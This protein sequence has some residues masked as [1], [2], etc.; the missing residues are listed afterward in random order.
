M[1]IESSVNG[2]P[3]G[4]IDDRAGLHG[5]RRERHVGGDDDVAFAR[6]RSAIQSSASSMPAATTTRSMNG[7]R[8]TAIG[9]LLT[10]TT[11]SAVALGDAIDLLLHRAGVGV[12][13]DRDGG[14]V[15]AVIGV[16]SKQP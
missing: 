8:G 12:D 1:P 6:A 9:L 14:E 4:A 16:A 13:V 10:T 11:L 2:L 3:F 5:A 15:A 7:S